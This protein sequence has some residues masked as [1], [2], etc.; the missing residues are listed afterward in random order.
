[1]RSIQLSRS[2]KKY[3]ACLQKRAYSRLSSKAGASSCRCTTISIGGKTKM[4]KYA[5]ETRYVSE[6]L[7]KTSNHVDSLSSVTTLVWDLGSQNDGEV[8][9]FSGNYDA[10]IRYEWTFC[11]K[12]LNATAKTYARNCYWRPSLPSTSWAYTE[13]WQLGTSAKAQLTSILTRALTI[14]RSSWRTLRS[15]SL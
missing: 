7:R 10:R 15:T 6:P 4:K 12:V 5:N 8:K 14:H 2:L 11:V 1:M 3:T 9:L 13:Q